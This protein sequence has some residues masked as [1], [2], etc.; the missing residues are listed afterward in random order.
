MD[1]QRINRLLEDNQQTLAR[2]IKIEMQTAMLYL[3]LA[4]TEASLRDEKAARRA[5]ELARL[6]YDTAVRFLP[7]VKRLTAEERREI[8][9]QMF[10]LHDLFELGS[11]A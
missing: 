3:R 9:E 11:E 7:Q 8:V 6:A 1:E 2:F 10:V 4:E 5:R